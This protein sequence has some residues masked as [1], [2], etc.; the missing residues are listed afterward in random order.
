MTILM[1]LYLGFLWTLSALVVA[2]LLVRVTGLA[3]PSD[4]LIKTWMAGG[5]L[6]LCAGRDWT[7]RLLWRAI[8]EH[9]LKRW[10]TRS[11]GRLSRQI[12]G[13]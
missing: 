7:T 9:A 1:A 8:E 11:G 3:Y 2:P 6:I 13:P 4:A 12:P 5:L 10:T